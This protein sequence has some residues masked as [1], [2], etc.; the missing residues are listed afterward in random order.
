MIR[1]PTRST[2]TDT[3]FPYTTLFRSER[4]E[5]SIVV[6]WQ[7]LITPD[8][9]D[10]RVSIERTPG[11]VEVIADTRFKNTPVQTIKDILAYVPGVISQTRMGDDAR[12]SLRGSGLSRASGPR[13]LST[14]FHAIPI[15]HSAR[16]PD[17]SEFEP[18][19]Y[20]LD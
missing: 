2:R 20:F 7:R 4:V 10:A 11:A 18:S 1:R 5:P 9:V 15:H 13:G 8:A 3:L 14:Y 19:T 17:I 16:L 12:V 6:T